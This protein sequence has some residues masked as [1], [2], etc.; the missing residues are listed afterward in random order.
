M[1]KEYNPLHH[2]VVQVLKGDATRRYEVPDY[3]E[4]LIRHLKREMD[5]VYHNWHQASL[6]EREDWQLLDIPGGF[7]YRRYYWDDCDCGAQSPVHAKDCRELVGHG[8]WNDRRL[9]EISD[10]SAWSLMS[11]EAQQEKVKEVREHAEREGHDVQFALMMLFAQYGGNIV[12]FERSDDW[13]KDNPPPPCSCGAEREWKPRDYHLPSCSPS[14]PNLRFEGVEINWYK[15]IGRGMSTNVDWYPDR[16]VKW[17]NKALT[18]IGLYNVCMQPRH[19]KMRDEDAEIEPFS[20]DERVQ[21]KDCK[22]CVSFGANALI[23][24]RSGSRDVADAKD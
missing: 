5:I 13:E 3:A 12:H 7:E 16:W 22:Y 21:C 20:V 8:E 11:E 9:R 2:S 15:Y 4:A 1:T 14:L 10:P 6:D 24:N 23:W 19:Q 18:V 17:F